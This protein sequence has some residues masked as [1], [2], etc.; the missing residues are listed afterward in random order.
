MLK[1]RHAPDIWDQDWFIAL[2]TNHQMFYLYISDK[3]NDAGIWRPNKT[4]FEHNRRIR[5]DLYK[6]LDCVNADRQRIFVLPNNIWFIGD[7]IC[8]YHGNIYKPSNNWM[9]AALKTALI[10]GVP[11]EYITGFLNPEAID[12]E[13]IK[14][15]YIQ[16]TTKYAPKTVEPVAFTVKPEDAT[17]TEK[18]QMR[19]IRVPGSVPGFILPEIKYSFADDEQDNQ[20]QI[21]LAEQPFPKWIT[22][23]NI[24]S[25]E[26]V[27]HLVESFIKEAQSDSKKR[28]SDQ[29]GTWFRNW[30]KKHLTDKLPAKALIEGE[31]PPQTSRFSNLKKQ[32]TK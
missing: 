5:I 2:E 30:T 6:F 14:N 16:R 11:M 29:L 22:N 10:S 4:N 25:A 15:S 24:R 32:T 8:T 19:T 23:N 9:V 18:G 12:V 27:K 17:Q 13:Q 26:T 1:K 3:C 20:I 21:W 28:D 31:S 7:Y